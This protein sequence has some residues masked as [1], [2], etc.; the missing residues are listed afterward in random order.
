[1]IQISEMQL[2][3]MAQVTELAI[4]LGYPNSHKDLETRFARIRGHR[5]YALFVARL[6]AGIVGWVQV[7]I[8][9][10]S[11]LADGKAEVGALVVDEKHRGQKIGRALLQQ[12]E[13]W[14]RE[15][16]ASLMRL[17]SNLKRTDAHR[18]YQREGYEISKSSHIFTKKLE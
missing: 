8:E 2:S 13:I 1:M 6:Q 10:L 5:D 17:R 7:H 14:A 9:P 18:F 12:A 3:D 15:N 16:G 11:L 4:Q